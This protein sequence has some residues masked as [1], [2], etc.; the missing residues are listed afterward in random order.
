MEA[1]R[2]AIPSASLI[3]GG[4]QE[5]ALLPLLELPQYTTR[6]ETYREIFLDWS[7]SLESASCSHGGVSMEKLA[8]VERGHPQNDVQSTYALILC[9]PGRATTFELVVQSFEFE[10]ETLLPPGHGP[11]VVG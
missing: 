1:V 4:A 9:L 11:A 5:P 3:F 8:V 6:G 2:R 10:T 7:L